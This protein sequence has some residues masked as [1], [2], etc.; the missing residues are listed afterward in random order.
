MSF[1]CSVCFQNFSTRIE[2]DSHYDNVHAAGS[3][4]PWTINPDSALAKFISQ[5]CYIC[6]KLVIIFAKTAIFFVRY[7]F[8]FF[9]LSL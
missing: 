7:A 5:V 4:V 9:A 2:L 3:P 8:F 6:L 1:N